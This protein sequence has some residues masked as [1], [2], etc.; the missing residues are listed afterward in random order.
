MTYS[1][2]IA[3]SSLEKAI[4]HFLERKNDKAWETFLNPK[5]MVIPGFFTNA[6]TLIVATT[7]TGTG[8]V[9]Q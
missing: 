8:F 6:I 1:F 5:L 7:L 2:K 4:K 3:G 9:L